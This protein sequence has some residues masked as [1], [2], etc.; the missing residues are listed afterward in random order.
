MK[1]HLATQ[2]LFVNMSEI[3]SDELSEELKLKVKLSDSDDKTYDKAKEYWQT[4]EPNVS[5]ML[6]GLPEVG[7]IGEN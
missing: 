4:V 6:G 5:G 2:F 7:F 1:F 3:V